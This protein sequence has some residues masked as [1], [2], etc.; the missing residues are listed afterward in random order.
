MKVDLTKKQ[1]AQAI[2]LFGVVI[3]AALGSFIYLSK[4]V[5]SS[6]GWTAPVKIMG[7]RT[8]PLLMHYSGELWVTFSLREEERRDIEIIH[9]PDGI[10]WSSPST[11][12]RESPEGCSFPLRVQL[13]KRPDGR[14]WFFWMDRSRDDD[15]S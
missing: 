8:N 11:L 7:R 14:L 4:G 9:S 12:V 2:V 3:I 1:C 5:D 6:P 15:F 10:E 13:L